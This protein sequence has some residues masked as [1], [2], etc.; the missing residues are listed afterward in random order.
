MKIIGMDPG[1][2]GAVAVLMDDGSLVDCFDMPVFKVKGKSHIDVHRLGQFI[3]S[4]REDAR[5]VIELVGAMPGQGVTSM[6][7]FG[8]AAGVLHGIVG[9]LNMPLQT[10]SPRTWKAHFHLGK[11][12]DESRR[13]ATRQWPTGPFARV[14]DGGRAEAA[15]IA[16]YSIAMIGTGMIVRD[17]EPVSGDF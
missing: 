13:T 1:I 8:F 12:K 7:T 10:V 5:A 16:L 9:A 6:F 3:A 11:D 14:K 17:R 4:H 15:L 2:S